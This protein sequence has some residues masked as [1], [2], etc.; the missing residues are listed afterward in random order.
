M[1]RRHRLHRAAQLEMNEA[2][3]EY[4]LARAGLGDEFLSVVATAIETIVEAP[5]RWPLLDLRHHRFVL[6]RFPYSVFYRFDEV[7][8]IVVAVAHQKQRPHY[9]GRRR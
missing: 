8:V 9:W 1:T 7:E 5:H 3:D 4:D 6:R 2:A